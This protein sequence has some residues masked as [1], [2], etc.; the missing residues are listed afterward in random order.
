MLHPLHGY[1]L[2]YLSITSDLVTLATLIPKSDSVYTHNPLSFPLET[3][4]E[5]TQD[6]RNWD[7]NK[8][9]DSVK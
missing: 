3:P 7:T 5:V 4:L 2:V 1:A 8:L 6:V 9:V